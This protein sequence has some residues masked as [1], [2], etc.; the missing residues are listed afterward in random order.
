MFAIILFFFACQTP[1]E[2]SQQSVAVDLRPKVRSIVVQ[3]QAFEQ[4]LRLPATIQAIRTAVLVPKVPGRISD[5]YVRVGDAVEKKA[6]LLQLERGDYLAG[7][8]EAKAANELAQLQAEQAK[9]HLARFEQ[10]RTEEAITEAQ[11]EEASLQASLAA[12]QAKRTEAGFNIAQSRL[13]DT[14]LR[15]PFAGTIIARNIEVGEM[16]GG[17]MERPPL[18]LAD[19]SQ[20]RFI[21]EVGEND[22]S[23]IKEG[24]TASLQIPASRDSISVTID[25]INQAVDPVVNT[26][27]VEG[28]LNNA[29]HKLLHGQSATLSIALPQTQQVS[30]ARS[31]L[32]NRKDGTATVFLLQ[33][34]GTIKS[35]EIRYG[36]SDTGQVPILEGLQA[37]DSI[38]ISGHTRL[39]DGDSVLVV[40]QE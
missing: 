21:A 27:Q 11:L 20:V 36:R 34:D 26:I 6:L 23:N 25:R 39:T 22:I 31:A 5:I 32:L 16:M 15:A 10:L 28:V 18:M 29:D 17:P 37:G 1:V 3:T 9:T 35:K 8:Q 2:E 7:Y 4:T 33:Q 24:L 38:L 13:R 30:V 12:G 40:G 19:L 14:K